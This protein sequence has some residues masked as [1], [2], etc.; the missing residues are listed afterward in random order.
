[1]PP[2]MK[3]VPPQF[4]QHLNAASPIQAELLQRIDT[5]SP[6]DIQARGPPHDPARGGRGVK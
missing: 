4:A 5:L 6:Q 2:I 3:K 1:M